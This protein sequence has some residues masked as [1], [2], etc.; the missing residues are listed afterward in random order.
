MHGKE[1]ENTY[2]LVALKPGVLASFAVLRT[3]SI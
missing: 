1:E 3:A 2:L